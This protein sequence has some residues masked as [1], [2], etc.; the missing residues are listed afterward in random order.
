MEGPA[1]VPPLHRPSLFYLL[2]G[3]ADVYLTPLASSTGKSNKVKEVS[4]KL[5]GSGLQEPER[6]RGAFSLA[7]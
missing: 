2:S 5:R 3:H 7:G 6:R 1:P 4:R